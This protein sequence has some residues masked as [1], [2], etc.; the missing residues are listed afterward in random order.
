MDW[1][2]TMFGVLLQLAQGY[3]L[4]HQVVSAYQPIVEQPSQITQLLMGWEATVFTASSFRGLLF[5]Q[6]PQVV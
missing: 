2:V 6:R 1:E 5:T 3:T 4:Q